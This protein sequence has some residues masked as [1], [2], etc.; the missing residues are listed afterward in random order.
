MVSQNSGESGESEDTP[1]SEDALDPAPAPEEEAPA[2]Q[3]AD[4][5]Q[6]EGG[7]YVCTAL[8]P[9]GVQSSLHH[10]TLQ[11]GLAG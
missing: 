9:D 8:I 4:P 5:E 2:E 1:P 11:C 3:P 6:N 10:R 7:E